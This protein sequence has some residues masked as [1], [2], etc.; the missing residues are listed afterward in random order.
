MLCY[1][2]VHISALVSSLLAVVPQA[3]RPSGAVVTTA[4]DICLHYLCTMKL[5]LFTPVSQ[6][7]CDLHRAVGYA[8]ETGY[9]PNT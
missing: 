3:K 9:E 1:Y 8:L 6:R 4:S 2:F 5:R 7:G